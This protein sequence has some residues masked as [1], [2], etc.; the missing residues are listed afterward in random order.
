MARVMQ[1]SDLDI[2]RTM[3]AMPFVK[4]ERRGLFRMKDLAFVCFAEPLWR[5]LSEGDKRDLLDNTATQ[6][7][8]CYRRIEAKQ[9]ST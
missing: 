8:A 7:E 6:I 4:F 3:L 9:A 2:E 5:K 1:L